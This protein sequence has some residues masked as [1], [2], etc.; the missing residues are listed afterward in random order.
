MPLV[1]DRCL[2]RWQQLR[3]RKLGGWNNK[4]IQFSD[5]FAENQKQA[6]GKKKK[7]N[8]SENNFHFCM[9]QKL[10]R[11]CLFVFD[12]SVTLK[13]QQKGVCCRRSNWLRS[14][15]YWFWETAPESELTRCPS[16][17][18]TWGYSRRLQIC[19]QNESRAQP[20]RVCQALNYT[21]NVWVLLWTCPG[22][23][24]FGLFLCLL[25]QICA[26]WFAEVH[27]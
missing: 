16:Q 19:R 9:S 13:H 7:C 14:R 4:K 5:R 25:E 27:L 24:A 23:C 3:R 11:I 10:W 12:S 2:K 22:V 15:K 18:C 1:F 17:P 8:S 20:K 21:M 26:N 6:P